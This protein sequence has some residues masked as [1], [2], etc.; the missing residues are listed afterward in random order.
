MP[1]PAEA[2]SALGVN[3]LMRSVGTTVAAAVMATI[4]AGSGG[5]GGYELCFAIGAAAAFVGV[6]ITALVPHVHTRAVKDAP[7]ETVA[8]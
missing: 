5:R 1:T 3:A 4:L 6:V 8:A 7:T 2:G